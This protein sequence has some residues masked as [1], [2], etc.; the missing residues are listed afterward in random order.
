MTTKTPRPVGR[1]PQLSKRSRLRRRALGQWAATPQ[2]VPVET[3]T[4]YEIEEAAWRE[5]R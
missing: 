1:L 2:N 5:S 4:R 3:L